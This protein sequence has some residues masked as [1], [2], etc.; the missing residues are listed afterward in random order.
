MIFQNLKPDL[1]DSIG[2]AWCV[3]ISKDVDKV[4]DDL[5]NDLEES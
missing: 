1:G 4:I 5:E 3:Q 2:I